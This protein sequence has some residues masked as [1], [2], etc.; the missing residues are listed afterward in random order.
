MLP[1]ESHRWPYL[2]T[3][4]HVSESQDGLGRDLGRTSASPEPGS[5][6]DISAGGRPSVTSYSGAYA[7]LKKLFPCLA[8]FQPLRYGQPLAR[9][10]RAR[11]R[12]LGLGLG[13]Q[14]EPS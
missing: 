5:D 10:A 11:D 3:V 4:A 13:S 6:L 9:G 14:Q 12:A 8:L 7:P 1:C 2:Q